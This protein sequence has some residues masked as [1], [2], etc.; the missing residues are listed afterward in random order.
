MRSGEKVV[1]QLTSV[2][3]HH[4]LGPIAL[5]LVK[6]SAPVDAE[7]TVVTADGTLLAAAQEIVVPP[8]AGASANVPRLPR[9]GG[10]RRE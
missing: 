10:V 3:R 6:R 5:A 8:E 7:L 9:L 4:E 1:G 2:A